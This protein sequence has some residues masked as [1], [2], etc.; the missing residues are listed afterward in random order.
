M[1]HLDRSGGNVAAVARHMNKAPMQIYRWMQKLG[2]DPR[3]FR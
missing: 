1:A 2:I 3:A